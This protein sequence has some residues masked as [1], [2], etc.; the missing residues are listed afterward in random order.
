MTQGDPRVKGS[1]CDK[2]QQGE[3]IL[4]AS[5]KDGNPLL[6]DAC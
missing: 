2:P 5:L 1:G 6:L 3:G 4:T